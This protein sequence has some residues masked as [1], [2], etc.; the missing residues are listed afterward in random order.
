MPIKIG[1]GAYI[2]AGF[3]PGSRQTAEHLQAALK[4]ALGRAACENCGRVAFW[5]IDFLDN[6]RVPEIPS[7]DSIGAVG[8]G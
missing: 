1:Q 5:R 6:P 7:L 3:A 8:L 2:A 4:E